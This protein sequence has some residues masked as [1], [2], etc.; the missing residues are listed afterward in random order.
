[1]IALL[2]WSLCTITGV[3]SALSSQTATRDLIASDDSEFA[4]VVLY[5]YEDLMGFSAQIP[6]HEPNTCYNINCFD[7]KTSSATW[8]LPTDAYLGFYENA[9]CKGRVEWFDIHDKR[10]NVT[11]LY[12]LN[13]DLDNQVSSIIVLKF[14]A[15]PLKYVKECASDTQV[16]GAFRPTNSNNHSS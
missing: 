10:T 9:N 5:E 7:D 12:P 15:G 3:A 8:K 14:G 6:I 1:M 11:E 2:L 13:S 16:T 4:S